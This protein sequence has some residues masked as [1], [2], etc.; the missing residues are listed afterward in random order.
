MHRDLLPA[1]GRALDVA[2]GRG[3]HACCWRLRG[4]DAPIC[5]DTCL[6]GVGNVL[7]RAEVCHDTLVDL[8]GEEAFETPDD[9]PS[10]PAVRRASCDVGDRRLVEPYTDDDGSIEGSVGLS[11]AT[12]IEAV[13]AGGPSGRGRERTGTAELREGGFRTNPVGVVA[14]EDEHLGRGAGADPEA[15]AEGGRRLSCESVEVPVVDRDFLGEGDPSAGER[16]E[17]VFGGRG[18][19]VEG[20]R[21][22]SS[23][24]LSTMRC[25]PAPAGAR[26][27]GRSR[28]WPRRESVV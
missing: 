5:Q 15:L 14:E 3:R 18:G 21:S 17:C 9:L 11:V 16:S 4:I 12:T 7:A 20:A 23:P 13:P 28:C 8:T 2:C 25:R 6:G 26:R 22:V 19:R 10:G 27:S 1:T 24:V